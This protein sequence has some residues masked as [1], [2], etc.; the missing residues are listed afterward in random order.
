M[1]SFPGIMMQCVYQREISQS[2]LTLEPTFI[3]FEVFSSDLIL[4]RKLYKMLL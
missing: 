3:L 1:Q 2:V 4:S